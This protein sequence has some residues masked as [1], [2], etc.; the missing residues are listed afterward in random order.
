ML[1]QS[2]RRIITVLVSYLDDSGSDAA[3]PMVTI[4]GYTAQFDQW[5]AFEDGGKEVLSSYDV[6]PLHTKEFHDG[7]GP[8][9]GWSRTKKAEFAAELYGVASR[10]L[11]IGASISAQKKT[12]VLRGKE[13]RLNRNT[14][15][16]GHCFNILV[17]RMIKSPLTGPHIRADG[18]SFVVESGNKNNQDLARVFERVRKIHGLEKELRSISFAGKESCVAIQL[19]D[20]LAF[21]SRRHAVACDAADDALEPS[22]ILRQV[23]QA[24]P[25]DGFIATDFYP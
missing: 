15:A 14:S 13:T 19:A 10:H 8:F 18:I 9:T 23:A 21:Y 25:H 4:A 22:G 6:P 2:G 16:I 11:M 20:F 17:D 12:Y 5:A 24:L 1:G 3:S 7:D